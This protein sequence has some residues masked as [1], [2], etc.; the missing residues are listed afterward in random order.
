[1]NI[2][3]P[4][5]LTA[6]FALGKI[7]NLRKAFADNVSLLIREPTSESLQLAKLI[8]KVK[9]QYTM[10]SNKN[11]ITL[12]RLVKR[13]DKLGLPGDIVECGV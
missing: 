13:A 6:D 10:V 1:M 5:L 11:L 7:L 4:K 3:W 2:N 12:Y 9:P 8:L